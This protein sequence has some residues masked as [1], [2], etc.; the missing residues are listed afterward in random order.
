MAL[1][2]FVLLAVAALCVCAQPAFEVASIKPAD[3]NANGSST[4]SNAG[5]I[6][7]ENVSLKDCIKQAFEVKDFS[8]SGPAWLDSA[9]FNITAK[10]PDGAPARQVGAM[11]EA[12]LAQRFGLRY[13]RETRVLAA[14]ALVVDKKGLKLQ[15][16]DQPKQG[17]WAMGPGMIQANNITMPMFA[18]VLSMQL[19]HPVKDMTGLKGVYDFKLRYTADDFAADRGGSD[20]DRPVPAG[21]SIFTLLQEQAGLKLEPQRLPVEILVVEHIERQPTAN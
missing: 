3:P 10:I 13:H 19:N 1:R 8:I 2:R 9:R 20:Q 16:V 7:M 6:T 12:L 14:Y 4:H 11:L 18:E 5:R 21:G 17:G 15:S